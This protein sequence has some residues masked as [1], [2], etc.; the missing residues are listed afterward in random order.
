MQKTTK[1]KYLVSPM[2]SH[3]MVRHYSIMH[4]YQHLP[5]R[6]RSLYHSSYRTS[7]SASLSLAGLKPCLERAQLIPT[8]ELIVIIAATIDDAIVNHH[9]HMP[10]QEDFVCVICHEVVRDCQTANCCNAL[11]CG[12]CVIQVLTEKCPNCRRASFRCTEN[13]A[14]QRLADNLDLMYV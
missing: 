8:Y 9:Y 5:S 12:G 3:D 2:H 11:F 10:N 6:R 13:V 14:L 1:V 4:R 7:H